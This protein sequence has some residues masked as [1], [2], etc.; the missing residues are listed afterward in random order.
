MAEVGELSLAPVHDV[1]GQALPALQARRT[2]RLYY[3]LGFAALPWFW[4]V[5]IWL[6]LPDFWHGDR[7]PVIAKC[8]LIGHSYGLV[9]AG[10]LLGAH[11]RR[12]M[13]DVQHARHLRRA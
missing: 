3:Y 5:N 1:D 12:A 9:R 6:F 10:L 13:H 11:I 7:D 2:A 4:V 8:E